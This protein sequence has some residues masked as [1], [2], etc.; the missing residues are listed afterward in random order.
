MLN[1]LP[2]YAI[3]DLLPELESSDISEVVQK[4]VAVHSSGLH[5]LPVV[6]STQPALFGRGDLPAGLFGK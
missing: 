4:F 2:R 6:K 5:F 1:L 3:V